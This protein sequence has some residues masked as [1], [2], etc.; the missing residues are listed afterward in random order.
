M[1]G[2]LE[3]I[4]TRLITSIVN[5]SNNAKYVSL[6]NQKVPMQSEDMSKE[7]MNLE[8]R[9]ENIDE[10]RNYFIEEIDQNEWISK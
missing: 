4:F 3:K 6:R 10:P 9:F 2:F 1:F 7:N 8:F 5:V